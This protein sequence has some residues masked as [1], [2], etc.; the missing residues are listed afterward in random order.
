MLRNS[1]LKSSIV[2][3]ILGDILGAHNEFSQPGNRIVE[4]ASGGPFN[5]N[6]GDWTDDSSMALCIMH[7]YL[8]RYDP[9]VLYQLWYENGLHSVKDYCFDIGATTK[10]SL[11]YLIKHGRFYELDEDSA[12]NGSIMRLAP[13]V[14]ISHLECNNDPNAEQHVF[15]NCRRS[16]M[17]THNN[18]IS[19]F[20]ASLMGLLI[21]KIA[22][23]GGDKRTL[24]L[25][26]ISSYMNV[27][28]P[29]PD[30]S[31]M[32]F[33]HIESL[34]KLLDGSPW[35]HEYKYSGGYVV[36]T[37]HDAVLAFLRHDTFE[38]GCIELSANGCD[39][40]TNCAVYGQISGAYYNII[41]DIKTYTPKIDSVYNWYQNYFLESLDKPENGISKDVYRAFMVLL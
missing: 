4:P 5:L 18:Q 17:S 1:K 26:A 34:Y 29:H 25:N 7:A 38:S 3:L 27:S 9:S 15:V 24:I 2:G 20:Y 36:D 19:R 31:S 13:I 8:L 21:Y 10:G 23:D 35:D 37:F 22:H 6:A 41:E 28:S 40:D 12:G 16:C 14:A 30:E 39:S 33:G 11:D 32:I